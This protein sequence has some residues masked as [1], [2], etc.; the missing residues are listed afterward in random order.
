MRYYRSFHF[1]L[2]LSIKFFEILE[3]Y[4]ISHITV[5]EHIFQDDERHFFGSMNKFLSPA[6][7]AELSRNLPNFVFFGL[8][9]D[10][11]P[12]LT[13]ITEKTKRK[14]NKRKQNKQT[15]KQQQTTG[16]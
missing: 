16:A 4:Q 14:Q 5:R 1:L 6:V 13:D 8:K 12:D 3:H 11:T 9:Y 2:G 15:S 7:W 10:S